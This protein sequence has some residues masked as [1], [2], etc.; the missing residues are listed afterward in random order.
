MSVFI[1]VGLA[2]VFMS[3]SWW[4]IAINFLSIGF[5]SLELPSFLYLSIERGFI[6]F[7]LLFWLLSYAELAVVK[8]K[9]ELQYFAVIFCSIIEIIIILILIINPSLIGSQIPSKPYEYSHT[10]FDVILLLG[11]ISIVLI[12]G[13]LFSLQSIQS[14]DLKIKWKG[15]FLLVSF[16]S[17]TLGAILNGLL[18]ILI[19]MNAVTIIIIRV[20]LISS[21][22]E[23]YL[24]FFLPDRFVK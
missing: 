24:G 13:I 22:I 10:L 18:H 6:M 19:P 23:Y 4:S 7:G 17:F 12:T 11:T 16:I 2:W 8:R 14:N 21:A 5:F 1:I 15:R 3:S 9:K 20:I